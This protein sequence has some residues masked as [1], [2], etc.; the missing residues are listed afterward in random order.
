MFKTKTYTSI[1]EA[2]LVD[3]GAGMSDSPPSLRSCCDPDKL[4]VLGALKSVLLPANDN[5]E[6]Q[7]HTILI[8]FQETITLTLTISKLKNIIFYSHY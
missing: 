5:L 1:N 4:S 8:K 7:K 2:R 6:L 3:V